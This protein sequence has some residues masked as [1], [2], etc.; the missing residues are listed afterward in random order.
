VTYTSP[1]RIL[2]TGYVVTSHSSQGQTA[3]RVLIH[4]DTEKSELSS[5]RL[6]FNVTCNPF[7]DLI[8][9][10][11]VARCRCQRNSVTAID[12]VKCWP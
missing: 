4:V 7:P 11:I 1:I 2:T 6:F 9:K 8:A 10:R 5:V 3:D 12:Q